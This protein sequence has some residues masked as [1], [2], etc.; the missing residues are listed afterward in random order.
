MIDGALQ[1][2]NQVIMHQYILDKWKKL[3]FMIHYLIIDKVDKRFKIYRRGTVD[4]TVIL[5]HSRQV[6]YVMTQ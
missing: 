3:H 2:K 5:G 6:S 1:V 4:S